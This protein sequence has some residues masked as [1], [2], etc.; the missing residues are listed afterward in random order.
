M[1]ARARLV[2]LT[3]AQLRVAEL[4]SQGWKVPVSARAEMDAAMRVLAG[5]FQVASDADAGHEVAPN[6]LLRAELTPQ[7]TGLSLSL[8]AAPFG[9]FGPRLAPGA[10]RERV[11]TVHAGCHLVHAARP[12]HRAARVQAL[13]DAAD[14]LDDDT[15]DWLLDEPDQALAVVEVLG[16]LGTSIVSEW[17]KGKPLRVRPVQDAAVRLQASSKGNWLELDGELQ[18]DGGEVL[19]LRQLLD[20]AQASRSRYVALGE[21]DFLALGDALAPATRRPGRAGAD[22][23]GR[24][25]PVGRRRAGL[26]GQ[27]PWPDLARRR[28]LAQA[29][30]GLGR[31][32]RARPSKCPLGLAA[33]L[34]DYQL[35]GYRWLMRLSD[36]GFGAVLADDMGLGKTVQTLGMLL[37][38][39]PGGPALV[40]A[41]TSVC[42]NWLLEA[43]RFA[44]GLQIE[45]YGD[46]LGGDDADEDALDCH[47]T[48]QPRATSRDNAGARRAAPG[49]R[50]GPGQVLVCSYALLQVDATSWP[51]AHVAQRGARRSAGHQERRHARAPRPRWRCRPT[52][53]WR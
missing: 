16:R 38:R 29:Q 44:P 45:L 27:R 12:G 2:R 33:E 30:P 5:H 28:G 51:R 52:S 15:H 4:V 19:R 8:R 23:Q 1:K 21:G 46:V 13:L 40:V 47:R 14:F 9:D 48:G 18:L 50:P 17:P 31:C 36:S 25:A 22:A 7:G 11:T 20:M 42:G 26:G 37:Q 43:A 53:G 24:P 32:A 41:P 35:E 34:R 10:G 39:A 3:P 6:S 49:A